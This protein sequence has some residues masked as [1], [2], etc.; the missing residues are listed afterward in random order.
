M[1]SVVIPCY[2]HGHLLQET[3]QSVLESTYPDLESLIVDDRSIEN[4]GE[5]GRAL[6]AQ[7]TSVS[8]YYQENA[9]PSAARN[10]GVS[11]ANGTYI[12]ALDADDLIAPNYIEEAVH[13]LAT[14]PEVKVVYAE[15]VKFGAVNKKWRLKRYS[16]YRLAMDNMIYVS[17]LYRR[18]DWLRVGGYTEDEVLVRED[19][20]FWIKL[21]K[22]GGEVVR[23]PFVGF[24]Y[25]IHDNSRRKS[26]SKS[27][28]NRE[29]DYL[30]THHSD[31]FNAQLGGPLRTMRSWSRVIN[32]FYRP[33]AAAR[34]H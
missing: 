17:A 20:E 13:V 10:N 1:V 15:A 33:V 28:K 9:G 7:Y 21:L 22:G 4:S 14:R 26:M 5:V 16:P 34:T 18:S 32:F 12:L 27:K 11:R 30:N 31:F 8:Y 25:R 24:Y 19:W 2:N 3:V 6:A 23:L 29:I